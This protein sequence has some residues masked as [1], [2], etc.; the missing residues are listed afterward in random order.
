VRPLS[1]GVL[2]VAAVLTA[3]ALWSGIV[4]GAMPLDVTLTRYL[5]ACAVCW[6]VLSVAADLIWPTA[7][8][9][10][11]DPAPDVAEGDPTH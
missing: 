10:P 7:T 8:L 2:A 6:V 3:P 1:G 4:E 5:L 11:E 9:A